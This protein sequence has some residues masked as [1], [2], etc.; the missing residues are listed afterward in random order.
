MKQNDDRMIYEQTNQDTSVYLA[1][2]AHVQGKVVKYK[3]H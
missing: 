3:T 2:H 1:H